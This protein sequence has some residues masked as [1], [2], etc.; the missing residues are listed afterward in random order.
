MTM[1]IIA[2]LFAL[3]L[4]WLVG[5][6]LN[7]PFNLAVLIML[8]VFA[9]A[10]GK[11]SFTG[12]IKFSALFI[13]VSALMQLFGFPFLATTIPAIYIAITIF[14]DTFPK[15]SF[16]QKHLGKIN[17]GILFGAGFILTV[18]A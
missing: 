5:L 7:N 17:M 8:Y 10:G 12:F 6:V 1:E 9:Y 2:R 13:A 15:E 11:Q 18:F 4:P 3:D 16:V 14:L